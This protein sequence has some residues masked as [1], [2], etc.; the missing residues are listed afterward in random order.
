MSVQTDRWALLL[1]GSFVL[2]KLSRRLGRPAEAADVIELLER[3]CSE[4]NLRDKPFL[5]AYFYDAPPAEGS[6][7]PVLGAE[8]LDLSSTPVK[9]RREA[10]LKKLAHGPNLAVRLGQTVCRGWRLRPRVLKEMARKP[11]SLGPEDIRPDI[12]QKGVDLRVGLDI[13]RLA[14]LHLVDT[15]VVVTGDSDFVPAF[16]FARREG[17]RVYLVTLD[18]GVRPEL[19]AH[20]DIVLD[21]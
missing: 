12:E 13:A 14:L 21:V 1:D 18:H 11:R 10:L 5:R 16:K 19:K 15:I 8:P 9:K 2:R 4:P 3:I 17:V 6:L 20:A 7:P